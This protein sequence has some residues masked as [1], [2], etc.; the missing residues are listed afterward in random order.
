MDWRWVFRPHKIVVKLKLVHPCKVLITVTNAGN[1]LYLFKKKYLFIY[2]AVLGLFPF[3]KSFN[4]LIYLWLCWVFV[5]VLGLSLVVVSGGYSTCC[6][7]ASRCGCPLLL[8]SMGPRACRLQ[9]LQRLL[10]SRAQAQCLWLHSMWDL[11]R[12]GTEHVSLALAGGFFTTKPPGK[13]IVNILKCLSTKCL[14]MSGA[15]ETFHPW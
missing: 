13:P 10:S 7:W 11:S 2:L 8:Q 14:K 3:F 12:S 1:I 9:Q 4:L 5:A 15:H 6:M